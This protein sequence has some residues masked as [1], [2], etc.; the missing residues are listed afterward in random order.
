MAGTVSCW[1][2]PDCLAAETSLGGRLIA[3]CSWPDWSALYRP[4][5]SVTIRKIS[6]S[7]LAGPVLPMAAGPHL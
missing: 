4:L 1:Y 2:L 7:S 6:L 5:S 3:I